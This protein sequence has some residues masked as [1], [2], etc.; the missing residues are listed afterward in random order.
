MFKRKP[1][2]DQL[3]TSAASRRRKWREKGRG[4]LSWRG[5]QPH[6]TEGC[7][8]DRVQK[9]KTLVEKP[10][11]VEGGML[12]KSYTFLGNLE[13]QADVQVTWLQPCSLVK[14]VHSGQEFWGGKSTY[15]IQGL[16]ILPTCLAWLRVGLPS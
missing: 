5:G 10:R 15:L 3:H 7:F 13:N 11:S 16:L 8:R 14:R 4:H 1:R 9:L 2:A 12:K 6:G